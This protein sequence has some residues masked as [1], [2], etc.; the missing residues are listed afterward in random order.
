VREI[1]AVHSTRIEAEL[2]RRNAD[3]SWPEE[4]DILSGADILTL[5]GIDY[6]TDLVTLYRT[7]ALA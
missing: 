7:T 6:A 4:P 5:A 3:G 2:L 1:V